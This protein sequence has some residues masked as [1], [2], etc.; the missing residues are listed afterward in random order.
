MY[1][2]R[3]IDN[4]RLGDIKPNSVLQYRRSASQLLSYFDT[5]GYSPNTQDEWDDL[6]VEWS[7]SGVSLSTYRTGLA[8]VEFCYPKLKGHLAWAHARL[9][10]LDRVHPPKHAAPAGAEICLLLAGQLSSMRRAR[11]GVLLM[12][13]NALG[14]RPSEALGLEPGDLRLSPEEDKRHVAIA[15]LGVRRGTKSGREQFALLDVSRW[16]DLWST[17]Q[18]VI[19]LTDVNERMFPYSLSSYAYWL[20]QAQA[21]LGLQLDIAP[22]SAR[23]GYVSDELVRGTPPATVKER[24]RWVS[25]S[26]FRLYVDAVGALHAAQAAR[27]AGHGPSIAY[28]RQNLPLYFPAAS[29][30][31]YGRVGPRAGRRPTRDKRPTAQA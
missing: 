21:A 15:R 26:A 3:Y 31:V 7:F 29:L 14:L 30:D 23:A 16:K 20:K 1:G 18:D 2:P 8:A 25:D 17:I 11:M 5:E 28:I 24:G 27:L 19:K 9:A 10:T 13:Q 12:L 22:H 4:E 6:L